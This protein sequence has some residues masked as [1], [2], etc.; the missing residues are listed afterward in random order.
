MNA[1]KQVQPT[2]LD[3][4]FDFLSKALIAIGFAQHATNATEVHCAW[5]AL[6]L[7]YLIPAS[8]KR[9]PSSLEYL[10]DT[11]WLR[12]YD[13]WKVHDHAA[14]AAGSKEIQGVLL[15]DDA[16]AQRLTNHP[17]SR[18]KERALEIRTQMAK[19]ISRL[20]Y[21]AQLYGKF[22]HNEAY[23]YRD[24]IDGSKAAN[25]HRAWTLI[26]RAI[27]HPARDKLPHCMQLSLSEAGVIAR[28]RGE[29]HPQGSKRRE[30]LATA[31]ELGDR[32]LSHAR[33]RG[34]EV[35]AETAVSYLNTKLV[36]ATQTDADPTERDHYIRAVRELAGR[37]SD[38]E[39]ERHLCWAKLL[40]GADVQG[41]GNKEFKSELIARIN[42]RITQG[43]FIQQTELPR[44]QQDMAI[45]EKLT[46][47]GDA[48]EVFRRLWCAVHVDDLSIDSFGALVRE[49][50]ER[51]SAKHL[52]EGREL[53]FGLTSII[54]DIEKAEAFFQERCL[55]S[56]AS[57]LERRMYGRGLHELAL[58]RSKVRG[59]EEHLGWYGAMYRENHGAANYKA[60]RA[61]NEATSPNAQPHHLRQLGYA[62]HVIDM[63]SVKLGVP[64]LIAARGIPLKEEW[65]HLITQSL[66]RALEYPDPAMNLDDND[67][68][69]LARAKRDAKRFRVSVHSQR[70]VWPSLSVDEL[71]SWCSSEVTAVLSTNRTQV[72]ILLMP[73]GETH[74]LSN[75]DLSKIDEFDHVTETLKASSVELNTGEI[76][77][78]PTFEQALEWDREG[79]EWHP[80]P[81]Y[82]EAIAIANETFRDVTEWLKESASRVVSLLEA[83]D[84]NR[85]L[86]H[87][88]DDMDR[89]PWEAVVLDGDELLSD[90]L[91]IVR[92]PTLTINQ[93]AA[94]QRSTKPETDLLVVYGAPPGRQPEL[95]MGRAAFATV[96]G[97]NLEFEDKREDDASTYVNYNHLENEAA[98]SKVLRVYAH[99]EWAQ[100]QRTGNAI[101]ILP[102]GSDSHPLRW[103][104]THIQAADMRRCKRVELW[105]CESAYGA[106]LVGPL[107][108]QTEPMGIATSFLIAGADCVLG[109]WWSVPSIATS[110]IAA[111]F[112]REIASEASP[113]DVAAILASAV[114]KFREVH[115]SNGIVER[116]LRQ[117]K[118]DASWTARKVEETG[119]RIAFRA[120]TGEEAEKR[121]F[122]PGSSQGAQLGPA[123]V[124]ESVADHVEQY[125]ALMRS[126][127]S[128]AGWRVLARDRTAL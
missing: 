114:K 81:I 97:T 84:C 120:M 43:S 44:W 112:A 48:L 90:R 128:W 53:R 99:G 92:C 105:A 41:N 75:F 82:P 56:A 36:S 24:R 21:T 64:T 18:E 54:Q 55:S 88:R 111:S 6:S 10:P 79:I 126:P 46:T 35:L 93:R 71:Q 32:S 30:W 66:N 1:L 9:L 37:A 28:Q 51:I 86:L 115:K 127:V 73:S 76:V 125:L 12:I 67:E 19:T 59:N 57:S 106:D 52:T 117:L 107:C 69:R 60:S 78:S 25:L 47:S 113:F 63:L 45:L 38:L 2:P 80:G 8:F 50:T 14:L 4:K 70:P 89:L 83:E 7:L 118:P 17:L 22:L 95:D 3:S 42:E 31:N 123:V 68:D 23:A 33:Q 94:E 65:S 101:K 58:L 26:Q 20:D 104:S 87:T 103:A 100:F 108:G 96:D 77:Q 124:S 116:Q 29:L 122:A 98:S 13:S 39:R 61:F 110:L 91:N 5:R 49:L 102:D 119:W 72:P 16:A 40:G 15:I 85:L 109:S 74:R 27:D 34:E 62:R 11:V 121:A